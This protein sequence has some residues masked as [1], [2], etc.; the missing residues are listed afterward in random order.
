MPSKKINI[1]IWIFLVINL[2][3]F[4]LCMFYKWEVKQLQNTMTKAEIRRLE[5]ISAAQTNQLALN[6]ELTRRMA[7]GDS[8]LN[9]SIDTQKKYMVLGREGAKLREMHI[10]I[11]KDTVAGSSTDKVKLT[12]PRGKRIVN[13]LVDEQ[14]SWDVPDWIKNNKNISSKSISG[15]LGSS[16]IFLNDG[17]IIYTQ[18]KIGP[19]NDTNYILPGSI[20]IS[21]SDMQAIQ[22]SIQP[23]MAVYFY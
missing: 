2:I 12:I 22:K 16:A 20:R 13:N 15:G 4:S 11:G 10:Q 21:S 5:A 17:T 6:I 3:L 19:L 7:K 23:G 14:Y 18:P 9:L 8:D 1:L